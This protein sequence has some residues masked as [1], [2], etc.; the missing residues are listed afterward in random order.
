MLN[1][2]VQYRATKFTFLCTINSCILQKLY[3]LIELWKVNFVARYGTT[4]FNIVV[5]FILSFKQEINWI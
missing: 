5:L 3:E 4:L 2:V 1:K